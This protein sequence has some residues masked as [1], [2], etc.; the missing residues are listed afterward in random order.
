MSN[1][2]W[3]KVSNA[4]DEIIDAAD[5]ITQ[6]KTIKKSRGPVITKLVNASLLME[7]ARKKLVHAQAALIPIRSN[8]RFD[9]VGDAASHLIYAA[10]DLKRRSK[11]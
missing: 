3:N 1:T 2:A 11:I 4:F 8:Y 7:S 6:A 5:L 10:K 9:P